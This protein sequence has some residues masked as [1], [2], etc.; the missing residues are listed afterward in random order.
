MEPIRAAVARTM[1][2]QLGLARIIFVFFSY[3]THGPPRWR[4]VR[5]PGPWVRRC[6]VDLGNTRTANQRRGRAMGSSEQP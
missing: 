6:Y 4:G 5:P 1:T 2:P 3:R